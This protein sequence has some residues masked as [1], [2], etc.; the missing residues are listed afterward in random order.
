MNDKLDRLTKQNQSLYQTLSAVGARLESSI[1]LQSA[2]V[3]LSAVP[4]KP[5]ELP[6]AAGEIVEILADS[7]YDVDGCSLLLYESREGLLKLMAA[8][9][10]ADLVGGARGPYN[11]D[12]TFKRG[13][14]IA[15]RALAGNIP[16]FLEKNSSDIELL[17]LGSG[18]S[19]PRSL[20]CL[21]L[22]LQER[23]I[24]VLNISFYEPKPFDYPR[25]Q[26]L[27]LLSRVVANIIQTFLLKAEVDKTAASLLVKVTE[28][29]REIAER[30][31]VEQALR[32]AH[33]RLE[34]RVLARTAG[35]AAAK[36]RLEEYID[37]NK[38]A[39]EELRQSE[40]RY[41]TLVE[42]SFDGIFIHDG[43]KIMFANQRAQEMFGYDNEEMKGLDF[44]LLCTDESRPITKG[45]SR[46]RL[47]GEDVPSQYEIKVLRRDGSVFEAEINAKAITL[48][49]RT[50]IQVWL[51]DISERKQAE[52]ALR[53]SE[54]RYR[55]L[56]ENI[57]DVVFTLDD[58]GRLTY[59]SPVIESHVSYR[60]EEVIGR[61]FT[62]LMHPDDLPDFLQN[63]ES[64]L[65]G[66]V[67]TFEFR[68]LDKKGGMHYVRISCRRLLK[69]GRPA[70]L[71]GI[72]TD[73]TD[74]KKAETALKESEARY[75]D[76]FDNIS[77]I[78]YTHDLEGRFLT[79]NQAATEIF[80]YTENE[81]IGKSLAEAI[82]PEHRQAFYS[83]YLAQIKK[84]GFFNGVGVYLAKDGDMRRL[85]FRSSLVTEQGQKPY[86]RG[87]ARD[88]TERVLAER[89]MRSL[90]E[91]LQQSQ[92]MQAVGTLAGGV[93]HDF[94]NIL[95]GIL[96][97]LDL[98]LERLGPKHEYAH[99]LVTAS[100]A[101]ERARDL[102]RQLLAFGRKSE[103]RK[104]NINLTK[105]IME[106]V[107]LLEQTIDRRIHLTAKA[108]PD[109]DLAAA[110]E[111]QMNQVI[112]NLCVNARD[113]IMTALQEGE[114]AQAMGSE[115]A[116]IT[117][118]AQ[119]V[120]LQK[121][122]IRLS[123]ASPGKYV[124]ISVSDTGC[125]MADEIQDRIFEPFFTTKPVDKGTGL[126]LSTVYGIIQQHEGWITVDSKPGR[127]S[128]F[129][130]YLPAVSSS[131]IE[132][133]TK[134]ALAEIPKGDE[135][136]LLVDDEE[137][138]REFAS[139]FLED[140]GYQVL[141]AADGLE[142][143]EIYEK[144]RAEIDLV[145]LDMV[146]PRLTGLEVLKRILSID[147]AAKIIISSGNALSILDDDT[148][149]TPDPAAFISKPYHISE[150]ASAIRQ[151]L[152]KD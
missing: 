53:K 17:K 128:A 137:M 46:A 29:E 94:N 140:L 125:G 83:D 9:G 57:N 43:Q 133:E 87:S 42:E 147:P 21:P 134:D 32:E 95:A 136:I 23:P 69:G 26:D 152:D 48:E 79:I 25:K 111:G 63:Y 88:I 81:I 104:K 50:A 52:T 3:K 20:A 84:H 45:R 124:K 10:Q 59:I 132:V 75:R 120:T 74:R 64:A 121:N 76:L 142:A 2:I 34:E 68:A 38:Q 51:R 77:D 36:L 100:G 24:G 93:A 37:R 30:R 67:Q 22:S 70:G 13:E 86:V 102:T 54:E 47:R 101:A 106:T 118:E 14:G 11:K 117:I 127:C 71:T 143:L 105:S 58:Q 103:P 15:G 19:A 1:K 150:M 114:P 115:H 112:M 90:K 145:I 35:L 40:E 62:T 130:I 144:R 97:N 7:L 98:A 4:T 151:V 27:L 109:L 5:Y 113:A 61:P 108:A 135:T 60:P 49:G 129:H 85:E 116:G 91:Q 12:L 123:S 82:P 131:G 141:L 44:S 65:A 41:R 96:G 18:L 122:E 73:I 39:E 55:N 80:G 126:G 66:L 149:I 78:I 33:D 119:N 6:D 139:E 16:Y 92:K 99:Y 110:D 56:V 8:T 148:Q 31:R 107:Q 138:I 146:M 72:L 28:V 89:E